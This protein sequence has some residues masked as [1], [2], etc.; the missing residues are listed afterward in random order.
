MTGTPKP[1]V[2]MA[3]LGLAPQ[4]VTLALDRLLPDHPFAEV[5][6]IHTDDRKEPMRSAVRRLDEQFQRFHQHPTPPGEKK[7]DAV[8]T[9]RDPSHLGAARQ[10]ELVY[11]RVLIQREEPQPRRL[12]RLV[13]ADDV[14]TPEN[15]KATFRTI[16]R[17]AGRYKQDNAIIHFSIAGGRKGMAVFGLATAQTLFDYSDGMSSLKMPS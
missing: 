8:Y 11:R 6:V 10:A 3:T 5:C 4:V 7:W 9:Y 1:Y 13:A 16:Y 14:E 15:S 12:P 2:F 17:V